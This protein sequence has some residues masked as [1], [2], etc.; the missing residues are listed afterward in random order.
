[1]SEPEVELQREVDEL[2][3]RLDNLERVVA[4]QDLH[5]DTLRQ[6]ILLILSDNKKRPPTQAIQMG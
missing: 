5:L 4:A 3:G 1:M 2:R 6:A